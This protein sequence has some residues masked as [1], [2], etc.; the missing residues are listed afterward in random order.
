MKIKKINRCVIGIITG[1]LVVANVFSQ[2]VKEIHIGEKIPDFQ[3]NYLM[4]GKAVTKSITEIAQGRLIILD[5][6]AT[7]CSPCLKVLKKYNA[8]NAMHQDQLLILPVTYESESKISVFLSKYFDGDTP[9]VSIIEDSVLS[10]SFPHRLLPHEVWI[11]GQGIVQAITTEEVVNEKNLSLFIKGEL[12]DFHKKSDKMAFDW[13]K[14]YDVT[15]TLIKARSLVTNYD[16]SIGSGFSFS[17]LGMPISTKRQRIF[18]YNNSALQLFYYTYLMNSAIRKINK[19]RIEIHIRDTTRVISPPDGNVHVSPYKG[20]YASLYD[21]NMKNLFSYELILPNPTDSRTVF[22][23]YMLADLNRVLP[24]KASIVKRKKD[25]LVLVVKDK[26]KIKLG[27][28]TPRPQGSTKR[29]GEMIALYNF[30]PDVLVGFLNALNMKPVVD[31]TGISYPIDLVNLRLRNMDDSPVD[32]IELR[33]RLN[34]NGLDLI[35]A[36]RMIDILLIEDKG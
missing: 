30:K 23:E 19:D 28:G 8:F 10:K 15:D 24:F 34:A 26:T 25:A 7:W 36:K 14:P 21:W 16:P 11:D 12:F 27:T 4:N 3:V 5:F 29:I 18:A 31:E 2:E 17:P 13:N 33:R 9:I 1:M 32:I 6:W 22:R 20:R 35:P